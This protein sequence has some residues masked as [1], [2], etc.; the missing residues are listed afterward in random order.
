VFAQS[1]IPTSREQQLTPSA[2]WIWNQV[3]FFSVMRIEWAITM[4]MGRMMAQAT[5]ISTPCACANHSTYLIAMLISYQ[6]IEKT[7]LCRLERGA[8]CNMTYGSSW[9]MDPDKPWYHVMPRSSW[10]NDPNGP[11]WY[12]GRYHMYDL[13]SHKF[14]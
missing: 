12:K 1:R 4:L 5:V 14:F 8:S 11:I 2:L 6:S 9:E 13:A 7:K 10:L 3:S